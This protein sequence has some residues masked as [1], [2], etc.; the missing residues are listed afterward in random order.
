MILARF[1]VG[2]NMPICYLT[3]ALEVSLNVSVI[4]E[5]LDIML[6]VRSVVLT[7]AVISV[8]QCFKHVSKAEPC[9]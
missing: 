4:F 3:M 8:Y 9:V 7:G 6:W 5:Y 1:E 2:I